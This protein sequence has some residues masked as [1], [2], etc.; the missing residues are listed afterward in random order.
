MMPTA[1]EIIAALGLQPHPVEGGWFRETY[2]SAGTIDPEQ[3]SPPYPA[4]RSVGTA[5]YYLLTAGNFSAMHRLPG[6]EIFHFYGGDPVEMF[7]IRD[8]GTSETHV[9]G[10][11]VP[12]GQRP[13][14]V[15]PGGVWQG[16]AVMA[17]SKWALLGTTMAPGFDY[18]DYETGRRDD[19]TARFPQHRARIEAL[20]RV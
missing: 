19:L 18:A 8:E 20:T 14:V 4:R 5:I 16:S 2:R 6:D 12:G 9:L 1:D 3:F 11:D 15:V 13:Q 7:L 17:P 10:A